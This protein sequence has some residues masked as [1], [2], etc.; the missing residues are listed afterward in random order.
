[1]HVKQTCLHIID[2]NH[3]DIVNSSF[4]IAKNPKRFQHAILLIYFQT[5]WSIDRSSI[6]GLNIRRI[7]IVSV[8]TIDWNYIYRWLKLYHCFE[9]GWPRWDRRAAPVLV[10]ARTL[11]HCL[12][13]R[14]HAESGLSRLS[15]HPS[16]L[17]YLLSLL[18]CFSVFHPCVCV[19]LVRSFVRP[20][21]RFLFFFLI[22]PSCSICSSHPLLSLLLRHSLSFI[23]LCAEVHFLSRQFFVTSSL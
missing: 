3:T 1:M 13:C 19:S 23:H 17:V 14:R 9:S 11:H 8:E 10:V 15:Y 16:L 5:F 6:G 2:Q 4:V 7:G 12:F 22:P 18:L 21:F 20:P